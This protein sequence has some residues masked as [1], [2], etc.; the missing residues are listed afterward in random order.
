[1]SIV[2]RYIVFELVKI[3]VVW[4][5]AFTA[6]MLTIVVCQEMRQAGIGIGVVAQLTPFLLPQTLAYAI[7][8]TTLLA[9]CIVYGRIAGAN[10][11]VAVKSLGIKPWALAWPAFALALLLSLFCVYL[12]DIAFSWGEAKARQ[13]VLE[14][15]EEIAYG[16][17]RTQRVYSNKKLSIVVRDV[18]DRKLLRPVISFFGSGEDDLSLTITADEAELQSNLERGTIRLLLLNSMIDGSGSLQGSLPGWTEREI[19]LSVFSAKGDLELGPTHIT[20]RDLPQAIAQQRRRIRQERERLAAEAGFNLVTGDLLEL[21]EPNWQVK[22]QQIAAQESRLHRLETELPRRTAS[23]FMCLFFMLIGVPAAILLKKSDAVTT[24]CL[25]FLPILLVY[26]VLFL[27]SVD[28]SK[29]GA[30]PPYVIWLP[31]VICGLIARRMWWYV[32]RY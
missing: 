20:L 12:N 21:N 15:M 8:A 17:L 27:A 14:S 7:P 2:T 9:A 22:R 5:G 6:L 3:L 26:F 29:A 18:E 13:V 23:G 25:C 1:M 10:E 4:L 30:W 28:R 11:A 32:D 24:F 31:N 16:V 19:P